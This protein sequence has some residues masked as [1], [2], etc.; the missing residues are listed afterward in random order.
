MKNRKKSVDYFLRVL[1]IFC[2]FIII[3]LPLKVFFLD[4]VIPHKMSFS[5]T[6]SSSA[7][8]SQVKI[9]SGGGGLMEINSIPKDGH[10]EKTACMKPGECWSF[11]YMTS[12][13]ETR[14]V[15]LT[16]YKFNSEKNEISVFDDRVVLDG[17][18]HAP[19]EEIECRN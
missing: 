16:I 8:I 9:K 15:Q 12:E 13:L 14:K 17:D 6:N 7:D 11:E 5:I 3:F 18:Y 4:M 10:I 1:I 19:Y 2:I